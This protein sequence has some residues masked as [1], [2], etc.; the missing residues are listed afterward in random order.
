M[1]RYADFLS[2][3]RIDIKNF[4]GESNAIKVLSLPGRARADFAGFLRDENGSRVVISGKNGKNLIQIKSINGGVLKIFLRGIY[5]LCE[6]RVLPLYTDYES[7]KI[8]GC[9]ILNETKA[10]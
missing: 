9:E 3:W 1:L 10:R 4:G 7:V 6:E 2:K 8:N 5:K